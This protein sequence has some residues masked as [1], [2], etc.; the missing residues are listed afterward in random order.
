MSCAS[1]TEQSSQTC[2]KPPASAA[3]AAA[4]AG[5]IYARNYS[6]ADI[7]TQSLPEY[8]SARQTRE[9]LKWL[10][11]INLSVSPR[12]SPLKQLT[13]AKSRISKPR[14]V[15]NPF[16]HREPHKVLQPTTNSQQRKNTPLS[17]RHPHPQFI[18]NAICQEDASDYKGV[19]IRLKL[20]PW[21]R[22]TDVI[23]AV[24]CCR[25]RKP[26][27]TTWNYLN[28]APASRKRGL[29]FRGKATMRA[30][31]PSED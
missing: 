2:K 14:V 22:R 3:A 31:K 17:A 25:A 10:S 26:T 24:S 16:S 5:R 7:N 13:G 30:K 9:W 1:S 29:E 27:P 19:V 18:Y 15:Y 28:H 12:W 20:C 11:C 6:D 4:A 8:G 23:K 21:W